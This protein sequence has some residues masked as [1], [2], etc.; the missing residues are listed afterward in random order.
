MVQKTVTQI[1]GSGLDLMTELGQ[2]L[3]T[4]W[5]VDSVGADGTAELTQV[6]DRVRSRVQAPGGA[7]EFDSMA[8]KAPEG[9]IAGQLVPVLKAL[10]GAEFRYKMNPRGELSDIRVPA[11]LIDKLKSSGPAA[12]NA[13][14]FSEDGLKNMITESSLALPAES[15]DV[16][17]AWT[18]VSRIP[19]PPLGTLVVKK[20]YRYEGP[21]Q[22][23]ERIGQEVLVE[24]DKA[25]GDQVEVNLGDQNSKGFFVFDNEVGRVTE[26]NVGQKL[27][28]VIKVTGQE[29][30]QTTDTSTAMRLVDSK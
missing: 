30:T 16:G 20:T 21:S 15:L 12:A 29:V 26:S 28:M 1:K 10:V 8:E 13:G 3:D 7:F 14:M 19:S 23:G 22:K 9:P 27:Q 17:K 5:K 6:I 4:T 25:L 2:T 24:L 11:G 18:R